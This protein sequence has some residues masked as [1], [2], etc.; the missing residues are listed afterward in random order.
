[1]KE[2]GGVDHRRQPTFHI[3][4]SQTVERSIFDLGSEGSVVPGFRC[5]DAH[6]IHVPIEHEQRAVPCSYPA[7]DIAGAVNVHVSQAEFC[8]F[9]GYALGQRAF[10]G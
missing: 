4:R 10:L 7:D 6:R 8:H 5:A 3:A 1:M 2:H 9:Y